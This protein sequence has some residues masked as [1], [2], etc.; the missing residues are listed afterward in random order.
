MP[1]TTK[2]SAKY[3]KENTIQLNIRLNRKTDNDCIK[4][5]DRIE[6]KGQPKADYVKSLMRKDIRNRFPDIHIQED[7]KNNS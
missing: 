6:E 3:N 2:G 5:L 4:V 1:S 7:I